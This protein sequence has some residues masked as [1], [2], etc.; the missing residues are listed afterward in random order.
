MHPIVAT[1]QL[2]PNVYR[3]VVEARREKDLMGARQLSLRVRTAAGQM[4]TLGFVAKRD[5][6]L[7]LRAAPA[8]GVPDPLEPEIEV[9]PT[10]EPIPGPIEIPAPAPEPE[11]E[12]EPEPVPA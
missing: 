8:V 12:P 4:G 1:D 5:V 2:S 9:I 7:G 11:R 10:V 3:L 6:G